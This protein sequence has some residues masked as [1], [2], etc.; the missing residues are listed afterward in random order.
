MGLIEHMDEG[1]WGWWN[2][3]MRE[4]GADGTYGWGNMV[5][6]EHWDEG[7]YRNSIQMQAVNTGTAWV[8]KQLIQSN[9]Y[10]CKFLLV[11]FFF[12]LIII[13]YVPL[14]TASLPWCHLKTTN[15]R[16]KLE[17]LK[18]FDFL[19]SHWYV[20]GFLSKRVALKTDAIGPENILFAVT[21]VHKSA[22]KFY[23]LWQWR[24]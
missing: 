19:F 4:H 15:K 6:M 3:L 22:R 14:L 21:F 24:G 11:F 16:M 8:R 5:L 13:Q 10:W 17:I 23:G 18:P 1:T 7:T 2:I 20:K 12:T 9:S